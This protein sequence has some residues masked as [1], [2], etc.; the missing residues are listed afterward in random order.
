MLLWQK[1]CPRWLYQELSVAGPLI[2]ANL[3][4]WDNRET[5]SHF[6]IRRPQRLLLL[7]AQWQIFV[8][9]TVPGFES[10]LPSCQMSQ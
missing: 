3:C 9:S 2:A 8:K 6:R 4:C 5:H 10:Y 1:V 7:L